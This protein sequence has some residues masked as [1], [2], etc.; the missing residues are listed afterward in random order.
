VAS[1]GHAL[2]LLA[3]L[4]VVTRR[5]ALRYIIDEFELALLAAGV[6]PDAMIRTARGD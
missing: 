5:L 1:M 6:Y 2:W 3:D 4:E